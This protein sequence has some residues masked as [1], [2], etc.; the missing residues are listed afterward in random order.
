MPIY[1][2]KCV[3]CEA[4]FDELTKFDDTGK[5]KGVECPECGSAKKE[6]QLNSTFPP[7]F[8]NPIGTDRWQ[9]HD[10]RF[11]YNLPNVLNQRE[12]AERASN[13][14]PSPDNKINDLKKNNFG[15]VK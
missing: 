8:A 1:I 14:G 15:K 13:V 7:Q 4:F 12:A 2:F 10:Y 5:Y 6:R 11:K 3:E 9:D